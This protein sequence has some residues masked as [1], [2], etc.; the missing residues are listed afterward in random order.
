MKIKALVNVCRLSIAVI[1]VGT[2]TSYALADEQSNCGCRCSVSC[3]VNGVTR[4]A[5]DCAPACT[6][7]QSC[8]CNGDCTAGGAP[9]AHAYC[10]PLVP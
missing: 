1:A 10:G 5:T 2:L 8:Y 4:T 7:E 6:D 9:A 3:T